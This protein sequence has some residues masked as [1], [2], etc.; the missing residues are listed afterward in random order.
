MRSQ[1]YSY[2]PIVLNVICALLI[3]LWV[4]TATSKLA[5]ISDFK[6]QLAKQNF[7]ASTAAFLF[8]FIPITELIAVG[9]LLF[10]KTRLLGV[11]GSF[12]LIS[13]FTGY[14]ALV[15]LGYYQRVP[16]SC[17]GVLKSLGWQAHFWFN[18]FFMMINGVGIVLE[19]RLIR[20]LSSKTK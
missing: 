18:L 15:I 19:R 7:G 3:V 8:W 14:I 6:N 13:L 9:L 4:Y 11:L 1:K 17:G 2:Q 20:D 10:S 16:C 5:N 12:I